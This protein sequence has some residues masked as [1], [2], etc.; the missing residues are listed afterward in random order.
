MAGGGL[1]EYN[2]RYKYVRGLLEGSGASLS[3][4]D[5]DLIARVLA[6]Y[7]PHIKDEGVDVKEI[8]NYIVD[9]YDSELSR[10]EKRALVEEAVRRFTT[11]QD[12][13]LEDRAELMRVKSD[14]ENGLEELKEMYEAADDPE[15]KIAIVDNMVNIVEELKEI[16]NKLLDVERL[17]LEREYRVKMRQRARKSSKKVK[18]KVV[19]VY[20]EGGRKEATKAPRET[21][22]T[23]EEKGTPKASQVNV[24]EMLQRMPRA[25]MYTT[26]RV[27]RPSRLGRIMVE[28]TS[29]LITGA[30]VLSVV[31]G[32]L[33]L[34]IRLV[35]P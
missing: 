8:I 14:L 19:I 18:E 30:I 1:R 3:R 24:Y 11:I 34:F 6:R 25:T 23:K 33:T 10:G 32:G 31:I 5:L 9:N 4:G 7:L 21:R 27:R 20:K 12:E 2:R 17:Q 35:V 15:E 22:E 13:P 29:T 28:L 26:R 16:N